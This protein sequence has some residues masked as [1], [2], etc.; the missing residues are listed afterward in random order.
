MTDRP[1]MVLADVVGEASLKLTPVVPGDPSLPVHGAHTS[2]IHYPARWFEERTIMLTT[3][4]RFV[5][6]EA[7]L[8]EASKLVVE[9]RRA[10]LTAMFF[11]VGV[12][13]DEVPQAL[14]IACRNAGFP[15]YAVAPEVP[16]YHIENF[17][18]KSK[19]SP[20]AYVLKRAMWLSNDLLQSISAEAPIQALIAR[21]A[22]AARGTAI[23]YE[24]SGKVV[25]VSG[26][27][28]TN[29][30]WNELRE[31]PD[32]F[33]KIKIGR[34]ELMS[35]SLVLRGEGYKLAIASRNAGIMTELGDALLDTAQRLLGAINGLNN[36]AISREQHENAQLLTTLQ[37][38][39]PVSREYRYWERMRIFRFEPYERVRS[40]SAVSL[41]RE[42]L[43]PN[44]MTNLFDHANTVGL[45]LLLAENGRTPDS[46]AG[47]HA[48]VADLPALAAWLENFSPSVVVGLSE[49]YS[50][51][52]ATPEAFRDAET[53]VNIARRRARAAHRSGISVKRSII[54]LDEVDPATWLLARRQSP[55]TEDKLDRFVRPIKADPE[56]TSTV[57]HYLARDQDIARVAKEMFVHANTVRYRLRKVE[58]LLGVSLAE[59]AAVTNLYLAFQDEVSALAGHE[60]P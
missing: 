43:A 10:G 15:L 13:F 38:G 42:L 2:E 27:G 9:L 37:D 34:W 50:D 48:L 41:G 47:L 24:D 21:L 29:L 51:L 8:D 40:L 49:P 11:G 6:S 52:A 60:G 17:V 56:L 5:G 59:A 16:F 54:L 19:V 4:L 57:I 14:V 30:I 45:G 18:N 3:G 36:L 22:A 26:D 1:E 32:G 33:E 58:E 28:P 23:L 55:R 12:Y 44:L 39:I 7:D 31:R 25:E 35:R 20:D 46:P 53:A